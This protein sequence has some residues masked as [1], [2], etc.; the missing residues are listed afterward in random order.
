MLVDTLLVTDFFV[1]FS[2]FK[3]SLNLLAIIEG[4]T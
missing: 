1:V 3:G 4:Q 2:S